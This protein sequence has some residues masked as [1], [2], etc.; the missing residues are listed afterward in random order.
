MNRCKCLTNFDLQ[1]S[2]NA[3]DTTEFCFQ[4]QQC[5]NASSS[6]VNSNTNLLPSEQQSSTSA[7][8][9]EFKIYKYPDDFDLTK[10]KFLG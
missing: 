9:S 8:T 7:S 2:H 5:K 1:C 3:K 6:S 10:E 4:H